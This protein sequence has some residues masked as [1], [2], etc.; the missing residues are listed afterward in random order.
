MNIRRS[1][2]AIRTDIVQA[3]TEVHMRTGRSATRIYLGRSQTLELMEYV[4]RGLTQRQYE[5][6]VLPHFTQPFEFMKCTVHEVREEDHL[7]VV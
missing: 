5:D 3:M 7:F 1:V 2:L 4:R 6:V